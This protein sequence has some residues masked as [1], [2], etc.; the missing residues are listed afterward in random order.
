VRE[1]RG[2]AAPTRTVGDIERSSL[3][4]A[5][6]LTSVGAATTPIGS[7][8]FRTLRSM[9]SPGGVLEAVRSASVRHAAEAVGSRAVPCPARTLCHLV[10]R[11]EVSAARHEVDGLVSSPCSPVM[12]ADRQRSAP[13]CDRRHSP[14]HEPGRDH[15][16]GAGFAPDPAARRGASADRD[17]RE[18]A[19]RFGRGDVDALRDVYDRYAGPVFTVAMSRLGD[20]HRAEEA[21]QDTFTKAWRAAARFDTERDLSPWLYEIARRSAADIARRER[22]RARTVALPPALPAEH[23]T[24]FEDSWA[25]WEVR[26]ALS[27]LPADDRELLRL[28]YY[29][30]L[31][32]SQ[33]AERLGIPLGTV[34]SRVHRIQQRLAERLAHLRG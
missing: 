21:V 10:A 26:R 25:A 27:A 32:Q 12:P 34:K 3:T 14:I 31:S 4:S 16:R 8:R 17:E 33:I 24:T 18:L 23:V 28:T 5:A 29:V 15:G 20:R 2:S 30:R 7:I 13:A 9:A 11:P 6:G 22:R 19:R 1:E